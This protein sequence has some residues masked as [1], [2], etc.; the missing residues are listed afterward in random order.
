MFRLST[1]VVSTL[2]LSCH[3]FVTPTSSSRVVVETTS[4]LWAS[5]PEQ[6]NKRPLVLLTFDLDDTL[7]PI[8]SVINEA[9]DAFVKAMKQYGFGADIQPTDIDDTTK[10]VRSELP[11]EEAAA[12]SH[13]EARELAI[14]RRMEKVLLNRKLQET[15]E[16]WVTSV[17]DLSPVVVENAKQ[18]TARAVSPS[19]V[20]AVMT[21]WEMERHHA[22]ERNLY[23]EVQQVLRE[24]KQEYP[25]V[26]LGAVTDGKANPLL[27]TFTLA[28]YF[29]FCMSWED[30]QKGRQQFFKELAS[31][32]SSA[33]LSWIYNAALEKGQEMATVQ[34]AMKAAAAKNDNHDSTEEFAKG[35]WIHVGDDLAYDVGGSAAC[36]AKTILCELANEYQQTARQRFDQLEQVNN[37]DDGDRKMP[38]WST[39]PTPELEVRRKMNEAA[40]PLVD[41]TINFIRELPDAISRILARVQD[42]EG[43]LAASGKSSSTTAKEQ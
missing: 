15:A 2:A 40:K 23:P 26:I 27:M 43:T 3:A 34:A 14:R 11:P 12:L 7:Y 25:H 20:K 10:Q 19:I 35:V 37:N 16:D 30:D 9:N 22:A 42:E 24:I 41:E 29:D 8:A 31:S 38:T 5:T 1:V 21:A 32:S 18:W 36:G 39:S 4:R 17:E 28:P 6:G 33:Q 13:T